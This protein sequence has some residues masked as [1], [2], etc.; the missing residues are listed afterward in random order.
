MKMVGLRIQEALQQEATNHRAIFALGKQLASEH[1]A[2]ITAMNY[3]VRLKNP[4]VIQAFVQGTYQYEVGLGFS[5]MGNCRKKHCT[6][7]K[8]R[9]EVGSCEHVIAALLLAEVYQAQAQLSWQHVIVDEKNQQ[10]KPVELG[11]FGV[12]HG[13]VQLIPILHLN[14][15]QLY[16][17][18][19]I[20]KTREYVVK[21]IPALLTA[22]SQGAYVS[23]GKAMAFCHAYEQ[24]SKSAQRIL[25]LV[26]LVH[27]QSQPE[28]YTFQGRYDERRL[29]I[30]PNIAAMLIEQHAKIALQVESRPIQQYV[31]LE[32]L[33]EFQLTLTSDFA[34]GKVQL[35]APTLQVYGSPQIGIIVTASEVYVSKP[36][37]QPLNQ[38]LQHLDPEAGITYQGLE[39][40]EFYQHGLP[41]IAKYL[42]LAAFLTPAHDATPLTAKVQFSLNDARDLQAVIHYTCGKQQ[43]YGGSGR[44]EAYLFATKIADFGLEQRLKAAGFQRELGSYQLREETLMYEFIQGD[45]RTLVHEYVVEMSDDFSKWYVV[46]PSATLGIRLEHDLLKID[47]EKLQFSLRDYAEV[48]EKYRLKKQYHRLAD[49]QF[50]DLTTASMRAA[51]EVLEQLT[52][53]EAEI[54]QGEIVRSQ[55]EALFLQASLQQQ[56]AQAQTNEAFQRLVSDFEHVATQAYTAPEGLSAKLRPYQETGVQWLQTLAAYQMGG[57]LAD[58]MGLGKTLQVITLMLQAQCKQPHLIVTP[59]SLLYNWQAECAKFA[60]TL[61]VLV[62]SGTAS[63][64]RALLTQIHE[65]DVIVT[66]YDALR[67]DCHHYEACEFGYL[68][69]DEAHIVKNALTKVAKSVKQMKSRSRFALT[70]TPIENSLADLWSLF[71]FVL[72]G[73]LGNY[74]AFRKQYER[75]ITK[76]DD[77]GAKQRL[78]QLTKP[79]ILRR[80]KREV[81]TELP[82]KIETTMYCTLEGEQRK[83]YEHLLVQANQNLQAEIALHGEK[84]ARVLMWTLLLRLRQVCC[85][86][87]LYLENYHAESAK[88]QLCLE[89]VQ[90]SLEGNHQMLI[91]SQFTSMLEVIAASLEQQGIPYFLLTGKTP[92]HVRTQL[93]DRFNDGEVPVFLI[94]LKAGGTGLN[95][96]GADVVIHYDPWWNL[97]AQNQA[98]DRAYRM[99]QKNVVQVYQLLAKD[100]IEE[101]IA[102]L[103][104]QK[105]GLAEALVQSGETF[106]NQLS[107]EEIQQLLDGTS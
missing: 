22:V 106:I 40:A 90:E 13:K 94:S 21:S 105:Q 38:L 56:H 50:L 76:H 68:I 17:E 45:L 88:L 59:K 80:L 19:R 102:L 100:T 71:D 5:K 43:F 58:D 12:E 55:Y 98:T 37:E 14:R 20:R 52:I 36:S 7:P 67:R 6:C 77:S 92:A 9:S 49:G 25:T 85:H 23:Y 81:L 28:A 8:F 107:F 48:A 97:S 31:K 89:L 103:Q 83:L 57:I 33:P 27:N 73:Y 78:H 64:R 63:Q 4:Y 1:A 53:T 79:F 87:S 60:P 47:V 61:N 3:D 51:I 29:E 2:T 42:D 93:A 39:V 104:A 46:N 35:Q 16:L 44:L 30:T 66:S 72:P 75:P 34:T 10:P 11:V 41:V 82:A 26:H 70:G 95:L 54:E 18:L 15:Q 99:G 74:L 62:V 32:R 69:L 91:F 96:T 86:P 101:R 24:F 65:Y 84:Q